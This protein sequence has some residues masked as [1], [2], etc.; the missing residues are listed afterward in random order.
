MAGTIIHTGSTARPKPEIARAL[1]EFNPDDQLFIADA[2]APKIPSR[3]K[4]GTMMFLKRE[5]F[6]RLESTEVAPGAAYGRGHFRTSATTFNCIKY[7]QESAVTDEDREIY[8]DS[9][10]AELVAGKR[11]YGAVLIDRESRVKDLIFNTTTWTGASLYT[12]NSG[13]PWDAAASGAIAQVQAAM[14]A[15]RTNCGYWPNALILNVVQ[16]QNLT[17][18]T[19][20]IAKFPGAALITFNM[21][22][23]ALASI[24]HPALKKL[25]I[26]GGVYNSAKEG[27]DY[28]GADIWTDDYAMVAK[29]ATSNDPAEACVARTVT[30][31]GLMGMP[32]NLIEVSSYREDQSDSDVIKVRTYLDEIVVDSAFAHLMKVD[33]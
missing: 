5:D 2:V 10:D 22:Q 16:L 27:Q 6:T 31:S 3:K 12:D 21:V 19:G 15:V 33:A 9:F 11:A 13:A 29:V 7:G 14:E 17:N 28:S 26:A 24:F 8:G 25:I 4:E 1:M 18:N 23:N 20:I 30:W 32:E